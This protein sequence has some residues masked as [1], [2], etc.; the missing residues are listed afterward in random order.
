MGTVNTES[1]GTYNIVYNVTDSQGNTADPVVT[2]S[3]TVVDT[4]PPVLTLIG[5]NPVN[6]SV[7]VDPGAT[8][9]DNRDGN[10]TGNVQRTISVEHRYQYWKFTII[11]NNVPDPNTFSES[12]VEGQFQPRSDTTHVW[13]G[14]TSES[15]VVNRTNTASMVIS[16]FTTNVATADPV[17]FADHGTKESF[18]TFK[19]ADAG[20]YPNITKYRFAWCLMEIG[21][22]KVMAITPDQQKWTLEASTSE[23]GP[24]GQ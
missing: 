21:V 12:P 22:Q 23:N 11:E 3:V 5:Q 19:F 16:R 13:G 1:L 6:G 4:T 14:G 24:N 10:I 20:S 9:I 8:A 17:I 15:A 18:V 7:Y 2:R